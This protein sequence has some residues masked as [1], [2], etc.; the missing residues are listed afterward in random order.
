MADVV[1]ADVVAPSRLKSLALIVCSPRVVATATLLVGIALA[2]AGVL[3]LAGMGWALLAS[4]APLLL[5]SAV[6]IRG[7][8]RVQE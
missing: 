6:L 8:L 2:V 3:V 4:S 1:D 5:L 7:L